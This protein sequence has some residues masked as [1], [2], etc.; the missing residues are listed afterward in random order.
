MSI[1]LCNLFCFGCSA[2]CT[3]VEL[4]SCFLTCCCFG[5]FTFVEGMCCIS[6]FLCVVCDVAF[7][8]LVSAFMPVCIFIRCPFAAPDMIMFF[9]IVIRVMEY[10]D[11]SIF[12]ILLIYS[13]IRMDSIQ[14]VH[15]AAV[16]SVVFLFKLCSVCFCDCR[17]VISCFIIPCVFIVCQNF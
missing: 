9:C 14:G 15:P 7:A 8:P 3:G 4:F 12:Q 17:N 16:S 13:Q 2:D 1:C 6:V 5:Y 10:D 11:I